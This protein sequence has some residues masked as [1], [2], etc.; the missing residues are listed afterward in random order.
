MNSTISNQDYERAIL[1]GI[2]FDPESIRDVQEKGLCASD[3]Y[4]PFHKKLFL[5]LEYL[6]E[7][8]AIEENIIKQYMGK[9][10][11]ETAMLDILATMPISNNKIYIDKVKEY[12]KLRDFKKLAYQ[13]LQKVDEDNSLDDTLDLVHKELDKVEEGSRELFNIVTLDQVEAEEAVFICKNWL[14]FPKNTVS[15]VSAGG[16]VGKSFLLLQAAMRMI[17]DEN[18]KVFMWL[19]EDALSLSKYR[20][21]MIATNILESNIAVFSK[22]LHIAGADSETIHFL[23]ESRAGVSV[24]P[25]FYQFKRMLKNYDVI[26]L[27]PLIAMFGADENNNAHARAFI[28]LFTRWAT[29]EEKTI[30]F[31]HHGTKNSS[32]SRGASAFVDAVRLVYR[33]EVIKNEA[34][35][36][37]EDDKRWI[38]LDKD[39][40]GAK[41]YLGSPKV[42]RQV[43]PKKRNIIEIEYE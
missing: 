39:N 20:A 30:I 16:G 38:L 24:S 37:I 6:Y 3:F 12:A 40:N 21:E 41:K 9:A 19:S 17:S 8:S 1:S 22:N 31:I 13:I 2:I 28:N 27:D 32:Q 26:I 15:L 10:F 25:K 43:F 34:G 29:K 36:I 33:V 4:H 35:E 23:E 14:P 5:A 42:K 18:L 7:H 11:D